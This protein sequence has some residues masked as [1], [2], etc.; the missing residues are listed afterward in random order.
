MPR[1]LRISPEEIALAFQGEAMSARFPPLLTI[2]QF[3]DLFQISLR[4]AKEWL[5]RGD[6]RGA[7]TKIGKHR[8]I[9]RE[10]AIQIAFAR[11][12]TR[13]RNSHQLKQG[14]ENETQ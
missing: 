6:F 12:C 9:W 5:G 8:R 2:P 4:T 7:T 13:P 11:D 14:E 1:P 10:R 3:A